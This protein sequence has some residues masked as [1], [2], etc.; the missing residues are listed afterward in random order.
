MRRRAGA[1]AAAARARQRGQRGE[2]TSVPS[3]C[4][5]RPAGR[6]SA[7]GGCQDDIIISNEVCNPLARGQL[8][9]GAR[10]AQE[11][12]NPCAHCTASR[13]GS[14]LERM[15]SLSAYARLWV[16]AEVVGLIMEPFCASSVHS[17][18]GSSQRILVATGFLL[19]YHF[20]C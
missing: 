6:S 8:S 3:A 19:V 20:D 13:I 16:A 18:T 12:F 10:D 5:A 7:T 17:S 11:L 9:C 4:C 14:R 2:G 1:A 15:D